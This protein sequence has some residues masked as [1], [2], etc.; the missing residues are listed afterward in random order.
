[1]LYVNYILLKKILQIKMFLFTCLLYSVQLNLGE[2]KQ[3]AFIMH[4]IFN[5]TCN[6]DVS[7]KLKNFLLNANV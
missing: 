4:E 6:K 2:W 1:M 5:K 7:N 3:H